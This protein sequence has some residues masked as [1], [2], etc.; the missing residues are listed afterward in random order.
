MILARESGG[1][2]NIASCDLVMFCY[3]SVLAWRKHLRV[4]FFFFA[5]NLAIFHVSF[6][7]GSIWEFS[8][9]NEVYMVLIVTIKMVSAKMLAVWNPMKSLV[10]RKVGQGLHCWWS[11]FPLLHPKVYASSSSATGDPSCSFMA[12]RCHVVRTI[13]QSLCSDWWPH[14]GVV[15]EVVKYMWVWSSGEEENIKND[16]FPLIKRK[17]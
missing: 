17:G 7:R 3:V 16:F 13:F 15:R 4:F 5:F 6:Y 14:G 8:K 1:N 10:F 2:L 11:P 12:Q 9:L